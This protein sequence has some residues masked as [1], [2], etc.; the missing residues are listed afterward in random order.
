M[1]RARMA[2]DRAGGMIVANTRRISFA[3]QHE[4]CLVSTDS[5]LL[6]SC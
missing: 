2:L 3:R 6:P 5:K 4:T 1:Q